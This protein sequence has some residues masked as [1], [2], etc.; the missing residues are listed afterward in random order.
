MLECQKIL[1]NSCLQEA[2]TKSLR[3][4]G[5]NRKWISY[6]F[7]GRDGRVTAWPA[8]NIAILIART[9]RQ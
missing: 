6:L 5:D 3:K 8:P 9:W 2:K 7:G 1:D 4:T